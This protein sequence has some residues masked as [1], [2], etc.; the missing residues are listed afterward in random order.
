M[1]HAYVS[2]MP[3]GWFVHMDLATRFE[4]HQKSDIHLEFGW[5]PREVSPIFYC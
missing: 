3:K 1:T 4:A 2:H 5:T